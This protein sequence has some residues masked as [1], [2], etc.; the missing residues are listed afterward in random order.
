MIC[1]RELQVYAYGI[2]F[3]RLPHWFRILNHANCLFRHDGIAKVGI[4]I[5][6]NTINAIKVAKSLPP[7]YR[8][9][10]YLLAGVMSITVKELWICFCP[11]AMQIK[12]K[13]RKQVNETQSEKEVVIWV[14]KIN[15][16][17]RQAAWISS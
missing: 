3:I 1:K 6:K 12:A 7:I 15:R 13:S 9:R 2:A 4:Q 17:K 8:R 16:C 11:L 5:L 10:K 14:S